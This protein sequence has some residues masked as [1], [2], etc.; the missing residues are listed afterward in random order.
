[1]VTL[2]GFEVP[3]KEK[4]RSACGVSVVARA[5]RVSPGI[6]FELGVHPVVVFAV[7]SFLD[8]QRS[9]TG[10]L[11][12]FEQRHDARHVSL[13]GDEVGHVE[14]QPIGA[15]REEVVRK[16]R[17]GDSLV[18]LRV[19]AHFFS[20]RDPSAADDFEAVEIQD[21]VARAIDDNVRVDFATAGR[22]NSS[23][24]HFREGFG[25]EFDLVS[26]IRHGVVFLQPMVP[27]LIILDFGRAGLGFDLLVVVWNVV[28]KLF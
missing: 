14:D 3:R 21:P 12:L 20:E 28:F 7:E 18:S 10:G 24:S 4:R 13:Y 19:V 11:L 5:G 27:L 17:L 2:I 22:G 1:M 23:R 25:D 8:F 15:Y 16:T 6:E 26:D 9:R